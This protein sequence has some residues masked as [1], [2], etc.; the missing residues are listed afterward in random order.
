LVLLGTLSNFAEDGSLNC[1]IPRDVFLNDPS[2][3]L[4][5]ALN[6]IVA[7]FKELYYPVIIDNEKELEIL[8]EEF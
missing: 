5:S 3:T 4:E 8:P 6:S 2:S 1:S 7:K